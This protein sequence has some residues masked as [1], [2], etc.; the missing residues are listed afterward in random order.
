MKPAVP[1][2]FPSHLPIILQD[3]RKN[4]YAKRDKYRED[5]RCP[6]N[7]KFA[8]TANRTRGRSMATI[9][10]TTTPLTLIVVIFEIWRIGSCRL[11]HNVIYTQTLSHMLPPGIYSVQVNSV[12][13]Q[14]LLKVSSAV[15]QNRG[16]RSFLFFPH[17]IFSDLVRILIMRS[18]SETPFS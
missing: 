15:L 4:L 14:Q 6:E 16:M 7:Q 9:E 5:N 10:V 1:K 11:R 12:I 2:K 3:S 17:G 8:L 18:T 13:I